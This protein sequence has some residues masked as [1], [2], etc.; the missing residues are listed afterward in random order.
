MK[1]TFSYLFKYKKL[2]MIVFFLVFVQVITQLFLPTLMGMIVDN[3]VVEGDIKYIWT[4]GAIMLL[5]ALI[6]VLV[7]IASS[8][9]TSSVV[10][11]FSKDL[12][13]ALFTHVSSFSLTEFNQIG[14]SSLITRT[15]NDVN[16][17]QQALMMLLRMVLTAP[18][19]LV[20]GLIMAFSKDFK[21]S[22]LILAAI[23]FI[24]LTIYFILKKGMPLFKEVQIRLDHLNRILRENLMGIRVI[25]AFTKEK[26]EEKRLKDASLNLMNVSIKVNRIMAFTMPVM[27]LLMNL[28]IVLIIWFGGFRIE[29][30]NMQIG[31]LMAFI[32]YVTLI[33]FALI[34]ASMMFVVIPRAT[35]SAGRIEAVLK[36][37][38]LAHQTGENELKA[39]SSI[40]FENVT[41]KYPNAKEAVLKD[42]NFEGKAGETIAI[43][44]GTG[45]G[46]T[47]L[48]NLIT[49][50]YEV[51]DGSIYV[52]GVNQKETSFKNLREEI[53]LVPQKANLF[54][55]TIIDNIR[56]GKPEA[57]LEEVK[58]AAKIAQADE[59]IQRLKDGYETQIEQGGANLS[60]GQKQRLAIARALVRQPKIYLFDDSFSA[61]DY[62][63]DSKLR[64][65]LQTEVEDA[66]VIIVGQ[67]VTS[68]KN[69]DKILVL[70]SGRIIDQGSHAELLESS[71]VYQEIVK[72]QNQEEVVK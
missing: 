49:R 14:T 13:E 27:M 67:R 8:Y 24:V 41:F 71:R 59:F 4:Y 39:S 22:L 10:S 17:I 58:Q 65:A 51:S 68:V 18:F 55:G 16:Q 28:T 31:D 34:M 11:S 43:I 37:E 1:T 6:G 19:M 2:L 48:L 7:A 56:Y 33:M 64:K 5:I 47:S 66:L 45:S 54:T 40:K 25:R 30:G 23:P 9:F 52:N 42:I 57:T 70:E 72:S 15:T 61:L 32:Q 50:L 60:G 69:A 26:N 35:V 38:K 29:Q 46:K 21:L 44:G 12:R 63:T 36:L 53:G 20:G 3:G 62:E